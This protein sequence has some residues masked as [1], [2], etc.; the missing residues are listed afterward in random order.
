MR[1]LILLLFNLIGFCT[2]AQE[3]L[4]QKQ[5]TPYDFPVPEGWGKERI[6]F[7][8]SFAPG[9]PYK[10]VE[11]IRFTPGWAK[12][13]SDEY[14]TY[15]FLWYLEGNIKLDAKTLEDHFK[16]YYEGLASATKSV[17][18]EKLIPVVTS[19]KETEVSKGD[20][21]TF[22]G[23][24]QMLDYMSQKPLTL[25]CKVHLLDCH[26]NNK[27]FVLFELSPQPLSHTVWNS[28][29]KLWSDFKT[30]K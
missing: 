29:D 18:R 5:E 1:L 20:S 26:K 15:I 9:I 12:A 2:Y 30:V 6:S 4:E 21:K 10:G 24:I 11:E 8:I 17:P 25:N 28:L 22:T 14:W 19:V 7:P 3:A 16:V 13:S 23:T 27:S